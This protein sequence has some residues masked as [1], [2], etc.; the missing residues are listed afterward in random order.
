MCSPF[1]FITMQQTTPFS[2][3]V[4][5]AATF[6]DQ[7]YWSSLTLPD[8]LVAIASTTTFNLSSLSSP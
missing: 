5:Q 4:T 6:S 8:P 1:Q 7:G 2:L 3:L